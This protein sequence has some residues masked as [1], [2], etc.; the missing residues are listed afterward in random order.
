MK[1]TE[2]QLR[3]SKKYRDKF[4]LI[5][6]RVPQGEKEQIAA[7]AQ[8]SG[9]SVNSFVKRAIAETMARDNEKNK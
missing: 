8:E 7:H 9:E 6:I 5:Q 1:Q 2:A 4:E 3:A